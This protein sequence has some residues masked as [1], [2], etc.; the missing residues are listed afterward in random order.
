MSNNGSIIVSEKPEPRIP[1]Q[2]R[3]GRL[4]L[5][6]T[7][8]VASLLA[9]L[10]AALVSVTCMGVLRLFVGVPTPVELLGDVILKQL[11]ASRFV[12]MLIRFQPNP[13]LAPLGLTLL[14]MVGLG[15][16]LG[17]PYAFV[18]RVS[19]PLTSYR[20]TRREWLCMLAF[21]LAMG[22]AGILLFHGELAQNFFGLPGSWATLLNVLGLLLDFLLYALV[23]GH[24]YRLLL[25]HQ[26]VEQREGTER[27][28]RALLARV[29]VAAVGLGA[30]GGSLGVLRGY[31]NRYSSYDGMETFTQN[32]AVAPIT[33]ND[34]HYVVTQNAID[35]TP[36]TALWRLEV[37]GL[38]GKSGTYTYEE[39]TSLPSISRA[40]TLEC[41]ANGI[42]GH[43][44]STAI[45]QAVPFSALLAR[46]GG[47]QQT[48]S[49]VVFSSVDGYVVS[50][51]LA[52]VLEADTLLAFRMN[53]AELPMRH[54]YPLR[55]LLPGRFGEE[56]PKWLTRIELTDH[57]EDGLYSSQGWYNGPLHTITRIDRPIG[58][59]PFAPTIEVGGLAF[60][61]NRGI[62]QVEISTDDGQTWNQAQLAP[63]LSKDAW[64]FWTYQW[65]PTDRGHYTL[66]ARATDGTG[67]LETKATQSTVPNG[68]TGYHSVPVDLA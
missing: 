47:P 39:F 5:L 28:R 32:G 67:Q 11:P 63:P 16:F 42:G 2:A 41:I 17:L 45:W 13:K 36:N 19:T 24:A 48:A 59:T 10:V 43:L 52:V 9:G 65:H 7:L 29:G 3:W 55:A 21:G 12:D 25:P 49:H 57:F 50:Q 54:G 4:R 40:V 68:A 14:G 37:T 1:E 60:A 66:S 53:G 26:R 62:Q 35:P 27:D 18:A 56:N 33:P 34:Q 58:R 64:V 8:L 6:F 20:S 22:L 15:V 30:A 61:G 23:L 31:L 46:H 38:V 51:P 44:I